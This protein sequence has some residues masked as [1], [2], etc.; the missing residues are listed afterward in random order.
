MLGRPPK[1]PPPGASGRVGAGVPLPL[2]AHQHGDGVNFAIFSRHATSVAL[3]LYDSPEDRAPREIIDLS[4]PRHRT[5]DIWHVWLRGIPHGQLYAYRADGP[6]TPV[7]GRRYNPHN[8]LLDPYAT[9][10]TALD[11]WDFRRALGYDPSSPLADLAPS[12]QDDT[13]DMPKCIFTEDQ[14]DWED[15]RPLNYPWSTTIIY[16]THVRGL[17]VHPSSDANYPGTYR[18]LTEKI[19]YLRSLGVTAVELMPVQEFNE[20]AP[21]VLNPLTG[22]R[23]KEYWGYNPVCFFAPKA[24]YSSDRRLGRQDIE[25]K[26][27]VKACHRA[28]LEVL[29]DV[30]FNHTAEGNELGPTLSL[31]GLDNSI[32]YMLT[33]DRRCYKNYSGTGNTVLGNHPVVLELILDALRYWVMEMHV[34]GFRF[35]LASVW[36]E[37]GVGSCCQTHRSCSASPRSY[38]SGGQNHRR[39]LGCR[40]S[41]SGRAFFR[42]ALGRVERLF[43]R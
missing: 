37:I 30:V 8:L 39:S 9:A 27:M 28:G 25:F 13:G 40:R 22:E 7:E 15:Y 32:Y 2:G 43:P 31:R 3:E 10:V 6:Y 38:P 26:E 35:D 42:R 18:G 34:D 23:L 16:E 29:L 20:D 36:P 4:S 11:H 12:E 17:T 19:P 24:S 5:G 1:E 14:Y 41:L 21:V 33:D